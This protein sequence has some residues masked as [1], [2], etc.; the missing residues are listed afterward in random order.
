MRERRHR[1][2]HELPDVGRHL[3]CQPGTHPE[4]DS[5]ESA[6]L[7]RRDHR[8]ARTSRGSPR[9][10]L[11]GSYEGIQKTIT[12]FTDVRIP[13]AISYFEAGQLTAAWAEI[14]A[15]ALI[16]LENIG[17]PLLTPAGDMLQNA[18]DVYDALVT[19][20][21]ASGIT[22]G[23]LGP[24][25]TLSFA[26]AN[27][28][29]TINSAV[30]RGDFEAAVVAAINTPAIA[31][32][33]FFNGYRPVLTYDAD[34]NPLTY[35]SEAFQGVF[36]PRG[37]VDQFVNIIPKAIQTALKPTVVATPAITSTSTTSAATVTLDVPAA[38]TSKVADTA[39]VEAITT[40]ATPSTKK[41]G[42]LADAFNPTKAIKALTGGLDADASD[43]STPTKKATGPR[44]ASKKAAAASASDSA[45]KHA[46]A[47]SGSD[48][49]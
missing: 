19:R 42:S 14:E 11:L 4:P 10:G 41:L 22:R 13:D 5:R 12:N 31:V 6:G 36:S 18:A 35:A 33:A 39:E 25:I 24:P 28:V 34:G 46:K 21:Q 30:A 45:P 17:Q 44:H 7:P 1:P 15:G 16:G 9:H 23:L 49:E 37:T 29:E 8:S 48:S 32:G 26:L 40:K 20:G 3:C 47:D 27:A 43:D 2:D 38:V